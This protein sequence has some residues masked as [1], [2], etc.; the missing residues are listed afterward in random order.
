[1]ANEVFTPYSTAVGMAGTVTGLENAAPTWV[2]WIIDQQRLQSYRIYEEIFWNVPDTFKLV[3]RGS[4]DKPIYL[5]TGRKIVEVCDRYVG[6]NFTWVGSNKS[7][8]DAFNMLFAREAFLSN[9]QGNKLYGIMRGDWLWHITGNP[10]K[11]AGSRLTIRSL[12]PSSYFPIYDPEDVDRIIGCR[13]I[14]F[15]EVGDDTL[16]KEL[17]YRKQPGVTPRISSEIQTYEVD[18]WGDMDARKP[19][20]TIQKETLLDP[21]ITALPVYHVRNF[22]EPQNPFG[23][24]EIRGFERIIASANQAISDQDLALA[25]DGLGMYA[26]N[27]QPVDEDGNPTEWDIGPGKVANLKGDKKETYFER[28]SGITSVAG[29][30][31]HIKFLLEETFSGAATPDI[32]SGKV[33]VTVAESGVALLLQLAPILSKAEKKDTLLIDTHNQ[34]FFDILH[35]WLPVYEQVDFGEGASCLAHVGEK[36]PFNRKQRFDELVAMLG[37][38]VIDTQYFRDEMAKL[39]YQ[40]PADMAARIQAEVQVLADPVSARITSELAS[41]GGNGNG[42]LT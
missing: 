13:I 1:M 7:V 19:T 35:G 15:I 26:S 9:F 10:K 4:E 37:L 24:S 12:D 21:R 36:L 38:K 42:S 5:P 23:S 27:A 40:F 32:A 6:N 39:G 11:P 41:M 30:L 29:S 31:E 34:M 22:N 2:P 18:E 3:A 17:T 28:V 14:E 8:Q 33:D 20:Q 16:I 25:M